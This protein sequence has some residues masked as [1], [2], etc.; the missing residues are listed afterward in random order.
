MKTRLISVASAIAIA[1]AS[2]TA[3]GQEPRSPAEH[4]DAKV[5]DIIVTARRVEERLQDVPVALTALKGEALTQL[6]VTTVVDLRTVVSSLN[7]TNAAGRP[8]TPLYAIR[9][10]RG[11][12]QVF[13]QDLPVNA[14]LDEV[15]ITPVAGSNSSLFDLENVQVVK[16][17]QGTLFGRNTTGGAILYTS[18][19]PTDVLGGRVEAGYGNYNSWKANGFINIPVNDVIRVRAAV[20][21][22]K[23][24]G[25]GEVTAG[26][27]IG[28]DVQGYES[29]AGRLSI[30]IDPV[31]GIKNLTVIGYSNWKDEAGPAFRI[32][33]TPRPTGS[34]AAVFNRTGLLDTLIAGQRAGGKFDIQSSEL[35][36]G[37]SKIWTV[38]NATT[39][40][41][42]DTL[43]FKNIFGFRDLDTWDA[44]DYDG[45]ILPILAASNSARARTYSDEVQLQGTAFDEKLNFIFGVFYFDQSG[46]EGTGTPFMDVTRQLPGTVAFGGA[47]RL[48][49]TRITNQSLSGF[50]QIGYKLTDKLTFNAGLRYTT[51]RRKAV[52]S[53]G[54]VS[55]TVFNNN[56]P[57]PASCQYLGA[58]GA[59]LPATYADCRITGKASFSQPSWLVGLDYKADPDTLIYIASRHSFRSGG[60]Q[61]RPFD[62][63]TATKTFAPEKVT[64]VEIGLKRDWQ[65]DG[66]MRLRTNIA[67]YYQW[68]KNIQRSST[69]LTPVG[70]GNV[71]ANAAKAHIQGLEFESELR[72]GSI[73]KIAFNYAYVDAKYDNYPSQFFNPTTLMFVPLDRTGNPFAYIPK[74]QIN[75]SIVITPD[76]GDA[77]DLSLTLNAYYTSKTFLSE[78][79][80]NRETLAFITNNAPLP[81]N[82]YFS[83]KGYALVNGRAQLDNIAGSGISAGIWGR[84]LLNKRYVDSA[85]LFQNSIGFGTGVYGSP[86][87]Y[88]IDVSFK[89]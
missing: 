1:A 75:G 53:V 41:L 19:K 22:K 76:V 28:K 27:E 30:A 49:F 8:A 84:N 81:A 59:P 55:K 23:Q 13:T 7:V 35:N 38:S 11:S 56:H 54:T 45:T 80:H 61:S 47:A 31:D 14:Y 12:D 10:Q 82:V 65:L 17:P 20:D 32:L 58:N 9:G 50:G 6:G 72:F 60:F 66:E 70:V 25:L 37:G 5:D 48:Q 57:V 69:T 42:S 87:T 85:V 15:L 39:V 46:I 36:G 62:N 63:T 43:T 89:F 44:V 88:G 71:V 86:R 33:D 40:E 52:S 3:Y 51:D 4:A 74:H 29:F 26:P 73:A 77:G 78:D 67:A 16:G 83:Q 24:G 79:Y 21:Y 68:Y 64:D 18:A 2:S 34:A